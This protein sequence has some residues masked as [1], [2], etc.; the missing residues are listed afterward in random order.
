MAKLTDKQKR[1]CEEYLKDFNAT[2]AARRAGY[3]EKTANEIGS[4]NLAKPSIKEFLNERLDTL[5][6]EAGEITKR[7]TNLARGNMSDYMSTRSVPYTPEIKV[8][9]QRL[10]ESKRAEIDFEDAYAL[11][12]DLDE[13][14]LENHMANQD[15]RRRQVIRMKLELERNPYA[16]RIVNGETVM[17]D[18]VYLDLAKIIADKERGIIKSFKHTKEGVQ[19]ELYNADAALGQMAKIRGLLV[20]KSEVDLTATVDTVVKVGYGDNAGN[21]S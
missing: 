5:S 8:G 3:S 13:E 19:V 15:S 7:I 6:M 11:E 12:V 20:D 18:E 10:I 17:V 4:E 9:L 1:F 2:A 16:T 14:D 21:A